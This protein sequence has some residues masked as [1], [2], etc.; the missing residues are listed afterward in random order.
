[1]LVNGQ[2]QETLE[3]SDRALHYGDGAFET[4][5]VENARAVH[6]RRH[7]LRLERTCNF[8]KIPIDINSLEAEVDVILSGAGHTCILKII[9]SRGSGGRGYRPP[10]VAQSRRIL[11]LHTLPAEYPGLQQTGIRLMRC[12]HPVSENPALAGFKH[13][14]RLDQ[15]L[16]S[17]ELAADCE[18]GVMLNRE[19]KVIEGTRSNLFLVR[20]N[21]LLTPSLQLA[22]VAGIQREII[23]EQCAAHGLDVEVR[24]IDITH[25]QN[26]DEIFVCNSVMGIWPVIEWRDGHK[27]RQL[28]PGSMTR[29]VQELTKDAD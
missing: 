29:R 27:T 2:P 22:G 24:D 10:V 21:R 17:M 25:L 15:V 4:L 28:P 6:W 18:E 23:L 9:V 8:L 19:G 14:N 16:A 3:L 26:A 20:H 12:Q 11:S 7:L 5:R 1:M 13:L